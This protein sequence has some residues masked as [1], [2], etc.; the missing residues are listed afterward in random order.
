MSWRTLA[1]RLLPYL[2]VA[3]GGFVIAYLIVFLFVFPTRLV[4]DDADVPNVVGLYYDDAV[5]RLRLAG[6]DGTRGEERYHNTAPEGAVLEQDPAGESRQ[7]RGTRIVLSTS[8][9]QLEAT[10]PRVVGLTR[11][12]AAT[13]LQNAGFA[14]G[15]VRQRASDAP[16]GEVIAVEPVTGTVLPVPSAVTI[17]ISTGPAHLE[18]PD[19]VGQ[20]YPQ[21]RLFLEQLGLRAGAPVYDTLSYMPSQ[22][23]LSQS[24]L[25]GA[26]VEPGSTVNLTVAGRG[27]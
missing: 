13:T 18:M 27:R 26:Q 1:R 7:P 2:V 14:L 23:V 22:T 5:R 25:P 24:P 15:D 16:R 10:V 3:A 19:V 6:F 4:P 8:R 20:S 9:G 21:A 17:T 11:R 12:Q